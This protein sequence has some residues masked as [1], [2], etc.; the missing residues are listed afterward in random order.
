MIIAPRGTHDILPSDSYKWHMME[1]KIKEICYDRKT[2]M[3]MSYQESEMVDGEEK[4][5]KVYYFDKS[6]MVS[7]VY[8]N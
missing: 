3:P 1:D 6:G 7:Q 8:S 5:I 2:G 4:N